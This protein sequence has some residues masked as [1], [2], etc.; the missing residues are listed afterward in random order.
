MCFVANNVIHD[1]EGIDFVPLGNKN[2]RAEGMYG[3]GGNQSHLLV[4]NVEFWTLKVKGC[5][6]KWN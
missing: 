2:K 1:E 6:L 4:Q 3:L 5:F